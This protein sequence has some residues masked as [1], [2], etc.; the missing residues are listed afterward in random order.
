[1]LSN[2]QFPR[3]TMRFMQVLLFIMLIT[4]EKNVQ[5]CQ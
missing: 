3:K 1:M 2:Q 4:N 5:N